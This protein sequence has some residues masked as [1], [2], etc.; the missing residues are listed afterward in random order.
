MRRRPAQPLAPD[1]QALLTALEIARKLGCE[2]ASAALEAAWYHVHV[3]AFMLYTWHVHI[4][5]SAFESSSGQFVSR[6]DRG[7]AIRDP[8][9][10]HRVTLSTHNS[11]QQ[12]LARRPVRD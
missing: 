8:A 11:P 7:I 2:A 9:H 3:D 4:D 12:Q 10:R 6:R 1:V 5:T